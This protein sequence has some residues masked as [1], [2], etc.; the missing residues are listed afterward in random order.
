MEGV[1]S[2]GCG[3]GGAAKCGISLNI[4]LVRIGY[5]VVTTLIAGDGS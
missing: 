1:G 4:G 3:G 5:E 2:D